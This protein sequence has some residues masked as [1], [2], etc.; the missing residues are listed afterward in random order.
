LKFE[1]KLT[2]LWVGQ[3]HNKHQVHDSKQLGMMQVGGLHSVLC[4]GF[5]YNWPLLLIRN[6]CRIAKMVTVSIFT[7]PFSSISQLL[8][9]L[10]TH[11]VT[12]RVLA[13]PETFGEEVWSWYCR[14]AG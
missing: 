14:K 10:H 4:M 6:V 11:A 13:N 12:L 2:F 7:F 3:S 1:E 5:V 9:P 8:L